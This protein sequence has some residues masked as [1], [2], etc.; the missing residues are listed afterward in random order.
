MNTARGLAVALLGD[1]P[2]SAQLQKPHLDPS[3]GCPTTKEVLCS[4]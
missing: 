4:T 3:D 2:Q 1:A